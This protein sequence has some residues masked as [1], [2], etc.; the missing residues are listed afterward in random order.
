MYKYETET[1]QKIIRIAFIK[2]VNNG[3]SGTVAIFYQFD[4]IMNR[5]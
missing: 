5:F 4:R 1:K 3:V 2:N